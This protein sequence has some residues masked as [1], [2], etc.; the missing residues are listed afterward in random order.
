MTEVHPVL[1]IHGGAT[2]RIEFPELEATSRALDRIVS[3]AGAILA[4]GGTALQAAAKAVHGLEADPLFNAGLGAK[5]Q[6]DGVARLSASAMDGSRARFGAV[7]NVQELCHPSLLALHLLEQEDRVLDGTG[8]HELARELRLPRHSPL[9]ELRFQEW[10][11]HSSANPYGTVGAVALDRAGRLAAMTS[12]GGKGL[13]RPG[14]VSDSATP[15]GNYADAYAAIS[16]TG[17]GEH[18]LECAVAPRIAAGIQAGGLLHEVCDGLVAALERGRR[19]LGFIAVDGAGNTRAS[20]T[21]ECMAHRVW[22]G[23]IVE[24]W[25]RNG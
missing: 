2:H 25:P 4:D 10:L 13:E 15:A 17:I 24:G 12:T 8:A 1:L 18:I 21:T 7:L 3:E 20:W 23:S 19:E 11:E 22:R 9:T 16:C 5:L 6:R 14:R